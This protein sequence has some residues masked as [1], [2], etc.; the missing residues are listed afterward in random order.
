[1]QDT[2]H[3]STVWQ[4]TTSNFKSHLSK[5]YLDYFFYEGSLTQRFR[6]NTQNS[7]TVHLVCAEWSHAN[8]DECQLLGINPNDDTWIR[9]I[10]WLNN[11]ESL[12]YARTVIP[13]VTLKQYG[14]RFTELGHHSMGDILFTDN[15][16]ERSAFDF[17]LLPQN[18]FYYRLVRYK[19]TDRPET[20]WAR[21]SI[22]FYHSSPLLLIEIFLPDFFNSSLH[23]DSQ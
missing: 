20:L 2:T 8:I 3:V 19:L 5:P 18:D 12:I 11:E 14:R 17:A 15:S 16:L 21:R 23:N 7:A 4:N 13:P 10:E 1:M 9:E 22:F 6:L